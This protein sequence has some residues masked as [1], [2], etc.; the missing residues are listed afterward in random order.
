MVGLSSA[1]VAEVNVALQTPSPIPRIPGL[2][3]D[4]GEE[5]SA[6]VLQGFIRDFANAFIAWPSIRDAAAEVADPLLNER[7]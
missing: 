6:V 2:S 1:G 7:T 3:S 4:L 5:E